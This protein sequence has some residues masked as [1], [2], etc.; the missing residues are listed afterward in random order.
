MG[1]A[2]VGNGVVWVLVG[3]PGKT[4]DSAVVV[5]VAVFDEP[6]LVGTDG[7]GAIKTGVGAGVKPDVNPV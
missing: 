3:T 5:G 7:V 1:C 4:K 2:T 6:P